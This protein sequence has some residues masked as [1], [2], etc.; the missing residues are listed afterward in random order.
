MITIPY[1]TTG[2]SLSGHPDPIDEP[3]PE[4]A[5]GRPGNEG[6]RGIPGTD[7]LDEG[8]TAVG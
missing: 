1:V 4:E 8:G 5:G 3:T 2:C 7:L 6:G